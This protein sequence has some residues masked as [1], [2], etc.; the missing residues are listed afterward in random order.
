MRPVMMC[1]APAPPGAANPMKKKKMGRIP[2]SDVPVAYSMNPQM[3]SDSLLSLQSNSLDMGIACAS[4][5]MSSSSEEEE[6]ADMGFGLFDISRRIKSPSLKTDMDKLLAL[7]SLQTAAGAFRYEKSVLDLVIGA[8]AKEF[9]ALCEGRNI[10]QDRWL[11]A[12]IIAFIERRF[13]A[14]KDTWEL[15]VEKSREWLSDDPLVE[16]AKKIIH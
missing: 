10:A 5:E 13:A 8:E 1:A 9:R 7:T 6:D 2:M 14:E 4:R 3:E 12:F 16:E 11:T 15:I